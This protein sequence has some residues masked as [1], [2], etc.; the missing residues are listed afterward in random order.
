[1]FDCR[2]DHTQVALNLK[3]YREFS[4]ISKEDFKVKLL[5]QLVHCRTIRDR[6]Q[7]CFDGRKQKCYKDCENACSCAAVYGIS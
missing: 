5:S 4:T 3:C 1:M 6:T 2:V 7:M